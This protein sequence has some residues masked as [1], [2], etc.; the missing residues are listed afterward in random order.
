MLVYRI[1]RTKYSDDLSGLGARMYGGRWNRPGLAA[2]Y[3]SQNRALA[4]LELIVHF[5]SK[6]ALKLD[7]EFIVLKLEDNQIVSLVDEVTTYFQSGIEYPCKE[8][9]ESLFINENVF[10][11]RVPSVI[12]PQEHNVI[13]N[14]A[15]DL[16][17]DVSIVSKEKVMLDGRLDLKH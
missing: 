3:T 15:H 2:L 8:K 10:A 14:P 9:T 17:K 5:N 12:V 16:M 6:D 7:Y 13:L 4:L 1:S 11:I